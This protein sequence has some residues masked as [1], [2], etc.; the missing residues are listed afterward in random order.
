[1]NQRPSIHYTELPE[2]SGKSPLS[3]E[4]NCFR[5]EV[6]RLLAEGHEGKF[7]SIKDEQVVGLYSSWDEAREAGLRRYLLEPFLV[8]YILTVEPLRRIRGYSLPRPS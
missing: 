5:R 6:V 4:W 8:Q 2:A 7:V 3:R 1:M